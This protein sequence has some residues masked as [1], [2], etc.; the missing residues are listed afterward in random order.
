MDDKAGE[1]IIDCTPMT[2][3]I[4]CNLV[5]AC[6]GYGSF[7]ISSLFI[8]KSLQW[9]LN[10]NWQ[11]SDDVLRLGELRNDLHGDCDCDLAWWFVFTFGRRF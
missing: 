6:E 3:I 9:A 10:H 1:F 4:V 2:L 7:K 8:I 5:P 11:P